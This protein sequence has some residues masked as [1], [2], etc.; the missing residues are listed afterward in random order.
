M[1]LSGMSGHRKQAM[2]RIAAAC[3]FLEVDLDGTPEVRKAA[4]RIAQSMRTDTA[5]DK[6]DLALVLVEMCY[7]GKRALKKRRR[8]TKPRSG[9]WSKKTKKK[10]RIVRKLGTSGTE[11]E[12][13]SV[14]V[15]GDR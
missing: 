5:P 3:E 8:A 11:E 9:N 7:R 15:K 6:E 13:G 14:F 10:P 2:A 4:R 1:L 12:D